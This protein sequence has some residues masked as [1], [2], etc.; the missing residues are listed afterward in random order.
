MIAWSY[1]FNTKSDKTTLNTAVFLILCCKSPVATFCAKFIHHPVCE[2]SWWWPLFSSLFKAPD[3]QEH[4]SC[5]RTWHQPMTDT[6]QNQ[7]KTVT[8]K[9]TTKMHPEA[10]G[11]RTRSKKTRSFQ[12][13]LVHGFFAVGPWVRLKGR[14]A[15][16]T[17]R[18]FLQVAGQRA[19]HG[20]RVGW[21][22]CG[23]ATEYGRHGEAEK[24]VSSW[25]A[26]QAR[27]CPWA[28]DRGEWRAAA[29]RAAAASAAAANAAIVGHGHRGGA[30][31][32][33]QSTP[34]AVRQE[35]WQARRSQQPPL[36]QKSED[37]AGRRCFRNHWTQLRVLS[38]VLLLL[39]AAV[40]K[41]DLNL[42]KNTGDKNQKIE[43]V[44]HFQC[45]I[46]KMHKHSHDSCCR[47][48]LHCLMVS[49]RTGPWSHDSLSVQISAMVLCKHFVGKLKTGLSVSHQ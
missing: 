9:K 14:R 25:W 16:V 31:G 20:E 42:E 6:W 17:G 44:W 13:F 12:N 28:G 22:T 29:G 7:T 23:H 40:L 46:K 10:T 8:T 5:Y 35:A 27:H 32:S 19:S 41:P 26:L 43:F 11:I 36:L 34:A 4:V 21:N 33:A 3:V 24:A 45:N 47:W 18:E 38:L 49:E 30:Q 1:F 48:L 15:Q 37:T 39:G 2:R